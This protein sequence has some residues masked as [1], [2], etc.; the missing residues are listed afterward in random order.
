[1][2]LSAYEPIQSIPG[3]SHGVSLIP[4]D[5]STF[6]L[7]AIQ[8]LHH[9]TTVIHFEP[10][11]GRSVL[12]V[13]TLDASCGAICWRKIS[14]SVTRDPKDKVSIVE[15]YNQ[16]CRITRPKHQSLLFPFRMSGPVFQAFPFQEPRVQQGWTKES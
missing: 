10:E 3:S 15:K 14:Y 4:L 13:L 9:G 5:T 12:C 11:S 1:M 8:R 2:K 16:V 7:D 6:D